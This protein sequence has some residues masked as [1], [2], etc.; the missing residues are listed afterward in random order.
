MTSYVTVSN[1]AKL[2]GGSNFCGFNCHAPWP[3]WQTYLRFPKKLRTVADVWNRR[4][5]RNMMNKQ[6]FSQQLF[7]EQSPN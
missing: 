6:M 1:V 2:L 3:S 7:G 5:S 4:H